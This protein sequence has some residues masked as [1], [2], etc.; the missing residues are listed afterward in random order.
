MAESYSDWVVRSHLCHADDERLEALLE[1]LERKHPDV[2]SIADLQAY[3]AAR[4]HHP[5][6]VVRAELDRTCCGISNLEKRLKTLCAV[7]C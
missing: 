2:L 7:K 4:L 3:G 6:A 5:M 1:D